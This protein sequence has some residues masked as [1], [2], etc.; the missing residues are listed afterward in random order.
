MA[1]VA[2]VGGGV[3]GCAAAYYLTEAGASVTLLER[4]EVGGQASGAAAGMLIPPAIYLLREDAQVTVKR[5]KPLPW[6]PLR[7][8]GLASLE[9]GRA[10][11]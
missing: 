3:I 10:H 11:V 9:I 5:G 8:L 4:G 2:I 7:D 6:G 1:D